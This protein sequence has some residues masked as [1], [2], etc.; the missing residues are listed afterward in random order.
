MVDDFFRQVSRA[1]N[2]GASGPGAFTL[3]LRLHVVHFDRV[4]TRE[5]Y[6][7]LHTL[8]VCNGTPLYELTVEFRGLIS[9][10]TGS[11]CGLSPATNVVSDVVRISVNEQVPTFMPTMYPGSKATD[12]RPYASLDAT[13]TAFSNKAYLP[14]TPKSF[15]LCLFRRRKR[16]DPPRWGPGP[17]DIGAVRAEC[18]PSR[19]LV[20]RDRALIRLSCRD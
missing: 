16:N 9:W 1:M 4:D 19:L 11:E 15:F 6:T 12:P 8:G 18:R 10:V 17:P 13:W 2:G 14:S 3:L 5:G 20:R 7:K